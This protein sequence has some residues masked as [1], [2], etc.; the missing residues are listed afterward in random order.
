MPHVYTGPTCYCNHVNSSS[1]SI[2]SM[3]LV[4]ILND[5]CF[6]DFFFSFTYFSTCFLHMDP[7]YCSLV[8]RLFAFFS[9]SL[10]LSLFIFYI[11]KANTKNTRRRMSLLYVCESIECIR[12]ACVCMIYTTK[13]I[14]M[15]NTK[16][17]AKNKGEKKR[18]KENKKSRK[19]RRILIHMWT[20]C[21]P[22]WH[23]ER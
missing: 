4:F 14:E 21:R 1:T 9:L 2:Y 5:R 10:S 11:F 13:I 22:N 17:P 18:R 3:G 6:F 15:V 20:Q 7:I 12:Y 16:Q 19:R 23:L 8:F